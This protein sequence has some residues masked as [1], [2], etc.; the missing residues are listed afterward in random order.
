MTNY[1]P[2]R[3]GTS[4]SFTYRKVSVHAQHVITQGLLETPHDCA[5]ETPLRCSDDN[6]DVVAFLL[7]ALYGLHGAVARVIVYDDDF[8]FMRTDGGSRLRQCAKDPRHKRAQVAI[9]PKSGDNNG[10][11]NPRHY[12]SSACLLDW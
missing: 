7:Q 4:D 12:S 8:D 11:M 5:T 10:V 1:Q 9:L 2:T 6:T 3:L